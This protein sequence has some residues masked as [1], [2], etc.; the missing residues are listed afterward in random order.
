MTM[1]YGLLVTLEA[2]EGRQ[3]ELA[4][5]LR[6][7]IE[8]V[9]GE[10]GTTTWYS[11]RITDSLFGIYDTFADEAARDAHLSG[12]VAAALGGAVSEL[13]AGPPSIEKIDIIAAK[14]AD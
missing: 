1:N 13:L 11:Y 5:F 6:D 9:M 7:S 2:K 8:P 14:A 4:Q 3:D 12:E 10:P